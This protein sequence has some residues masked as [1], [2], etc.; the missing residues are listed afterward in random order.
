MWKSCDEDEGKAWNDKGRL[1]QASRDVACVWHMRE[2]VA[3]VEERG[4]LARRAGN[5]SGLCTA[6]PLLPA[7]FHEMLNQ[8]LSQM[9]NPL[10]FPCS[11][12]SRLVLPQVRTEQGL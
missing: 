3:G 9:L 1:G 6:Y 12:N 7:L 2:V 11:T 10:S 8:M 5:I 4:G